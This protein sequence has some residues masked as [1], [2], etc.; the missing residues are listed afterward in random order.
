MTEDEILDELVDALV[1]ECA[2]ELRIF[3]T[4]RYRA[5]EAVCDEF[6]FVLSRVVSNGRQV[7][8]IARS[9]NRPIGIGYDEL[10]TRLLPVIEDDDAK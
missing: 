9:P 7:I 6:G 5:I 4:R 10:R 3:G 8:E 2:L 1:V